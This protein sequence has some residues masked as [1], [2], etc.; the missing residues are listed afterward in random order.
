VARSS[1]WPKRSSDHWTCSPSGGSC[2]LVG[3]DGRCEGGAQLTE[4]AL[5]VVGIGGV[6]GGD[7]GGDVAVDRGLEVTKAEVL[8]LGVQPLDAEAI[9]EGGVDLHRLAGDAKLL[10]ERHVLEGPHVVE[11]V[12]ELD[13]ED[14]DV[15]AHR[16]QHLA[17]A[18][19]LLL[20]ARQVRDL[21]ELGDAVDEAGDLAAEALGE[22]ED[23][24]VG[25]LDGV[26]QEA[27]DDAVHVEAD[28]GD[29]L[30]DP[31]RVHEV[32]LAALADL[33]GVAAARELEGAFDR[34]RVG[35]AA[36]GELGEDAGGARALV[37]D[38]GTGATGG[39]GGT[40]G[41][42]G[43][44]GTEGMVSGTRGVAR[45]MCPPGR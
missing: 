4:A 38:D 30:G 42:G 29:G 41:A 33:A 6:Q 28:A 37:D 3:G 14:A 21:A 1:T 12:G 24:E 20:L 44:A 5:D 39:A 15:L 13:E 8:Q 25:V 23:R 19:G 35:A 31:Q 40:D 43:T 9:G 10:V 22:V 45:L 11:A 2:S 18:L 7:A 16:Q 17:E 32:G 27:G 36:A 26:V 34:G